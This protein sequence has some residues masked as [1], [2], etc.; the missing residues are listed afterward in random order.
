MWYFF[1]SD[2]YTYPYCALAPPK[3]SGQLFY[4][5]NVLSEACVLDPIKADTV[6]GF[7]KKHNRQLLHVY[8]FTGVIHTERL[9]RRKR[10]VASQTNRFMVMI[11]EYNLL[12]YKGPE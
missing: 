10:R 4:T 2:L 1:N 12:A 7:L 5:E 11:A 8:Y 9:E 3:W 6:H